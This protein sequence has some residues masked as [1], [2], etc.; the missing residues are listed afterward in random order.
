MQVDC[1]CGPFYCMEATSYE[2]KKK[3]HMTEDW[4]THNLTINAAKAAREYLRIINEWNQTSIQGCPT[5]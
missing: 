3:E 2:F 4:I 5:A 1:G